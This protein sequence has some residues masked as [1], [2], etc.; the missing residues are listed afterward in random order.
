M[1]RVLV[2]EDKD[3]MQ[4]FPFRSNEDDSEELYQDYVDERDFE[5]EILMTSRR[6]RSNRFRRNLSY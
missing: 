2:L 1:Q 6:R 4:S 5:R 3:R